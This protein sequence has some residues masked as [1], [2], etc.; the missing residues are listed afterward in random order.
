MT[1][2]KATSLVLVILSMAAGLPLAAGP[3]LLVPKQTVVGG[4][5]DADAASGEYDFE[6][7]FGPANNDTIRIRVHRSADGMVEELRLH[8]YI[9]D[10]NPVVGDEILVYLDLDNDS[11]ASA[12]DRGIRLQRM[13]GGTADVTSVNLFGAP[14]VEKSLGDASCAATALWCVDDP[15]VGGWS[16]EVRVNADSLELNDIPDVSGFFVFVTDVG[17]PGHVFPAGATQ[18]NPNTWA[19][20]KTRYPIDYMIVLDQSG[21]MLSQDKW[22]Q[23]KQAAN[24]FANT[25]ALLGD[26]HFDDRLGLVTF[27]WHCSGD[28]RTETAKGLGSVGAFPLGAYTDAAPAVD[29]PQSSFCTPIESGMDSA[30]A[31][32]NL[33]A[34]QSD[35]ATQRERAMLLLS[36]GL[37][38]RPMSSSQFVPDSLDY[39][40]CPGTVAWNECPMDT[41]TNVEVNTVAFGEGDWGV[42]TGL[43]GQIATRFMGTSPRYDLSPPDDLRETFL[44]AL[45][46]LYSTNLAHAGGLVGVPVSEG[47]EK[48]IAIVAWDTPADAEEIELAVDGSPEPCA[49][50]ATDTDVGFAVCTVDAPQAG[51]WTADKAGEGG[52]NVAPDR[53]YVV[54]DL[55]VRA[56]FAVSPIQPETGDALLLTAQ[57]KDRGQPVLDDPGH[58]VDVTVEIGTPEQG[59]GT[60]VVTS[61]PE[62]CEPIRPS[63]PQGPVIIQRQTALGVAAQPTGSGDPDPQLFQLSAQLLDACGLAGLRRGRSGLP[64]RDDGTGGDE[65]AGDGIYSRRFDD[66]DV[67]GSYV[68]RFR[69]EGTTADGEDFT[70]MKRLAK[71]VRVGTTAA[72]SEIDSRILTQDGNIVLEEF[73]VLP[74]DRFGGYLGPGKGRRVDFALVSGPGVF[75]GDVVDYGNGYYA[76]RLR[77]DRSRGEPVVTPVVD[78]KRLEKERRGGPYELGV[79][80][81]YTSFDDPLRVEDGPV[82]GARIARLF[83]SG[84]LE[85][86]G[87]ATLTD[88]AAGNSGRVYQALVNLRLDAARGAA[89]SPFVTAGVGSVLF[90]DF[91]TEDDALLL[92]AGAGVHLRLTSSL[93]LRADVRALRFEDLFGAGATNSYQATGGLVLRF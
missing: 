44:T 88:D 5:A 60:F 21:S 83:G 82:F 7:A 32:G 35:D 38:N 45:E 71:Y 30:F 49:A 90:R 52:F 89:L 53:L 1:I 73:Y 17:N 4:V 31:A 62:T 86:E 25:M 22:G 34:S 57:L 36:D 48:L 91:P 61:E 2:L 19:K 10:S 12:L 80:A 72:D 24:L 68:F 27:S 64:L 51:T 39:D 14:T 79:F 63:L 76:R 9:D 20:L 77:Y 66:T 75:E 81:G 37:H 58:P 93:L 23:A 11:D 18:P 55:R 78:G 16:A 54:L 67:A 29:P 92:Q 42:D 70:R 3:D 43:L 74:R 6:Q 85:V 47:N 15:D 46:P 8:F 28:D 40:P 59:L 56:R 65:V 69:V 13:D 50:S 26:P 33:D 41:V 84:A 87:A